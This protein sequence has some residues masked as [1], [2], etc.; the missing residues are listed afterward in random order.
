MDC[1]RGNQNN[2]AFMSHPCRVNLSAQLRFT[3][4]YGYGCCGVGRTRR[5]S[6]EMQRCCYGNPASIMAYHYRHQA[7]LGSV[8]IYLPYL[9]VALL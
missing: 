6:D 5:L 9:V 3:F 7:V 4:R 8:V 2:N 1:T